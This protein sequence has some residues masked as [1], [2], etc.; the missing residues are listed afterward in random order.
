MFCYNWNTLVLNN[1]ILLKSS[2]SGN[3]ARAFVVGVVHLNVLLLNVAWLLHRTCSCIGGHDVLLSIYLADFEQSFVVLIITNIVCIWS[4]RN[5][6]KTNTIKKHW[7]PIQL[8]FKRLSLLNYFVD[9]LAQIS[10]FKMCTGIRTLEFL[11]CIIIGINA[12]IIIKIYIL[13]FFN[14]LW[15]HFLRS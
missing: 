3:I 4:L 2:W 1:H 7:L 9:S 5:Q 6:R 11:S 15:F 13:F 12:L 8:N 10:R 14:V